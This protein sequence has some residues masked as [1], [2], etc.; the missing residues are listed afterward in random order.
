MTFCLSLCLLLPRQINP[1][2][3]FDVVLGFVPECIRVPRRQQE[4]SSYFVILQTASKLMFSLT[5]NSV[6]ISR[7]LAVYLD[8]LQLLF[9]MPL[10]FHLKFNDIFYF[11]RVFCFVE[12]RGLGTKY[13]LATKLS[14][15]QSITK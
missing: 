15:T 7:N 11:G 6:V 14:K 13:F 9:S 8:I 10:S 4:V 12:S 2:G 3:L 5:W 1:L